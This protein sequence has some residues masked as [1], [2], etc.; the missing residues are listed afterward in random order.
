METFYFGKRTTIDDFIDDQIDLEYLDVDPLPV[1]WET[2]W[3]RI[4]PNFIKRVLGT[5]QSKSNVDIF[6]T[7]SKYQVYMYSTSFL[8]LGI[9]WKKETTAISEFLQF[10]NN[11]MKENK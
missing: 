1:N 6:L 5:A 9:I 4:H 2:N 7:F 8:D 11:H 10:T 3:S